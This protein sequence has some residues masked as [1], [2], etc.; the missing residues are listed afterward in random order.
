MKGFQFLLVL[1]FITFSVA[2]CHRSVRVLLITGGH[3]FDT[4][5]FF[6]LFRSLDGI[7]FEAVYQ[8]EALDLLQDKSQS[9]DV[10]VF[11]DFVVDM[12]KQDSSIFN[13]LTR[14]GKSMLFLHHALCTFQDWAGYMEMVGG[15]YVMPGYQEDSTLLSD[16]RHDIE[17]HVTVAD[18]T[19]P[20]TLDMEDFTIHDEGYSNIKVL[21]GVIP[22][23]MTDHPDASPLIGWVNTKDHSRVVYL[24]LGH[25]K[26]AYQNPSYHQLISQSIHWLAEK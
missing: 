10:L 9:Y 16:Y 4:L 13:E 6:E 1:L 3:S 14:K 15:R 5:E 25:D 21:P 19:H 2:G 18:P 24:M 26:Q 22:L 23:L 12:P 7:E 20:V 17:M 8:P 11:Y